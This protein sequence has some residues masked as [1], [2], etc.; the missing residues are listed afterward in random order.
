MLTDILSQCYMSTDDMTD[1]IN[2][3]LINIENKVE[4]GDL[5]FSSE[6]ELC[7]VELVVV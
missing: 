6:L 3:S 5:I 4:K 2:V 1:Q 7:K